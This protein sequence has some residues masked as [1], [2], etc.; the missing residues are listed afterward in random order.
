MN[1][2]DVGGGTNLVS[3]AS[4]NSYTSSTNSRLTNIE[5]TTAS[6]LIETQNLETFSASALISLSNLNTATASLFTSASLSLTTASFAG[7]TLTFRKGDGTTFGVV[8]PDVSGSTINTGSF[9]TTGSNAFFGTNTFSGAVAFTGSAPRILSSS[10][11]GSII[12]NLTDTYTDV[13]AVNQIVTLTS[14]SYAALASGSLTNP[15]TLYIVSGSISGSSGGGA[16]FPFTGDA[17]ITGSL[18]VTGSFRGF[19]SALTVASSTA[20]IDMVNGN[21]FTLN[22]PTSSTTHIS[23]TNIKPGQT[24]N[25]QVS[26]SSANTGSVA[27]APNIKFAGGFDYTATAITGALDLLSFVAFDANQILATSVKNLL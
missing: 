24:I 18:Q 10:F 7:N 25:L 22:L 19:V 27:F 17:V 15:N 11:S 21:F 12:T 5:S 8:I 16:A 3:T 1:R 2:V 14:A 26:Q 13:A 6:L 9:A 4:F 20:S 23:V